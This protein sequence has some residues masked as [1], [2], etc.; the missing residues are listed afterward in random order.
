MLLEIGIIRLSLIILG[1]LFALGLLLEAILRIVFGFGNPLIYKADAEIGYLLAPN[2]QTRRFSNFIAVNQYSMR[3]DP[4]TPQRPPETT[5]IMLIG[6][7][8]ANGSWWTDQKETIA[9]LITKNLGQNLRG[10]VQVLNASANSWGPR[11]QLA[12]L[13]RFGS[14]ESQVIV[15]LMN[16]DDL[17]ALAPSSAVVGR[18]INYPDRRPALALIEL[19]DRYFKRYPPLPPVQEGGDRVG[20]NLTALAQI[21]ALA[22]ANQSRLIIAITPLI[23]EAQKQGRDYELKARQRLADFTSNQQIFYLDFLPIFQAHPHPD[24]LYRDNIHLS[25]DGND[26]ISQKLAEAIKNVF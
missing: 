21:Q 11:N 22:Q 8:I 13:R 1:V 25:G 14:F 16:T 20:N 19:Y 2:Q 9:A 18:E 5:R 7:S 17:F 26:L 3:S 10:S 15:L 24:S 12:Y 4:I 6:D 23:R